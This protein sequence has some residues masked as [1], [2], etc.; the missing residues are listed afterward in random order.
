MN[1]HYNTKLDTVS[2]ICSAQPPMDSDTLNKMFHSL[3]LKWATL[4]ESSSEKISKCYIVLEATAL[5]E[6]SHFD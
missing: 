1:N 6:F 5:Y 2:M 3:S 4:T